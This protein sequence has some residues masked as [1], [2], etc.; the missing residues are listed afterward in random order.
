LGVFLRPECLRIGGSLA[1]LATTL[2]FVTRA[3]AEA[4]PEMA[5]VLLDSVRGLRGQRSPGETTPTPAAGAR[6]PNRRDEFVAQVRRDTGQLLVETLGETRTPELRAEG[7]AATP[8]RAIEGLVPD[9][10]WGLRKTLTMV[11]VWFGP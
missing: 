5:T 6:S 10:F 9:R 11:F 8:P 7:A 4:Q 1:T 3:L 2:V